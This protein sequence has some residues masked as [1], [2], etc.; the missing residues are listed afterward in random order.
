[1]RSGS[2]RERSRRATRRGVVR[3]GEAAAEVERACANAEPAMPAPT[4]TTSYDEP[5]ATFE[6]IT[7]GSRTRSVV[8]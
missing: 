4:M 5:W 1:M 7:Y 6:D 3:D 2:A 8:F